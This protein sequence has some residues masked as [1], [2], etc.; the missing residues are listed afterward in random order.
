MT[1][2]ETTINL[3]NSNNQIMSRRNNSNHSSQNFPNS[4]RKNKG[5]PYLRKVNINL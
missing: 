5:K 3:N 4:F 2:R 1:E